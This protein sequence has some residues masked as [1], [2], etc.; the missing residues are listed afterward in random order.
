MY[1][2][3]LNATSKLKSFNKSLE[4]LHERHEN[5]ERKIKSNYW[6]LKRKLEDEESRLTTELKTKYDGYESKIKSR[7]ITHKDFLKTI[8][9]FTELVDTYV[10][11]RELLFLI[12]AD[13][14]LLYIN[15]EW[16]EDDKIEFER[17]LS[18]SDPW[19][20]EPGYKKAFFGTDAILETIVEDKY[21]SIAV[22]FHQTRKPTNKYDL[23]LHISSIFNKRNSFSF[24]LKSGPTTESLKTYW[25]RNKNKISI[26][27]NWRGFWSSLKFAVDSK[28]HQTITEIIENF[29]TLEQSYEQAIENVKTNPDW[30]LIYLQEKKYYYEN[31]YSGGTRTDEYRL[32]CKLLNIP[33]PKP[34]EEE[35][36]V[37]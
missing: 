29:K 24:T 31:N 13:E 2:T 1:K 36:E 3:Y 27:P 28:L 23:T 5:A 11:G 18:T 20:S 37:A 9:N 35:N 8:E 14:L 19:L 6:K 12:P 30:K 25:E 17:R 15:Q 34:E 7:M 16:Y 10:C 26:K 21:K 4:G 33:L 22:C 32:I